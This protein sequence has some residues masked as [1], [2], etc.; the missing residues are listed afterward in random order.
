MQDG[1]DETKQD[2]V[3]NAIRGGSLDVVRFALQDRWDAK[4]IGE[5]W[6]GNQSYLI[7]GM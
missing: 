3:E 2:V 5:V 6:D 4:N 7:S 1:G